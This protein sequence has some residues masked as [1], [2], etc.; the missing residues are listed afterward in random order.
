MIE[1]EWLNRKYWEENLSL[2]QVASIDRRQKIYGR[3]YQTF[4]IE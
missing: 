1:K 4:L 2:R 3:Q